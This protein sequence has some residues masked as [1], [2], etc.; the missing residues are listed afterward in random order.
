MTSRMAGPP[1]GRPAG[2]AGRRR[3]GVLVLDSLGVGAAPDAADY[4]EVDPDA[5]TLAHV[6]EA[7]GGL[8]LPVLGE[9]G[10][11]LLTAAPGVPG[12]G[13]PAGL[14]ARLTPTGAGKDSTT[15]HWELMGVATDRPFPTYPDGFPPEVIEAFTRSIGRPVLGNLAASGTEIIERL[16]EEHL[17]TGHPIV[18]T[19]ADSVL[20]IATHLDVVP[21]GR[22][23]TWCRTA[24]GLLTGPHRVG[25]VIARP[26]EGPPGGFR[27]TADRRDFG[28]P[29][30]SPTVCDRL[31]D[32]GVSVKAAGK[33][34]DLFHHRGITRSTPTGD[35]AESMEA[36]TTG[37]SEE[38]PALVFVNAGDL[39]TRFGHRNDPE[40]Y[41]RALERLDTGLATL[42][43]H[44]GPGDRLLITADHGT[45]PTLTASTD[46]TRERVPCLLWGP[47]LPGGRDLGVRST[48]SDVGATVLDL[49]GLTGLP[50]SAGRPLTLSGP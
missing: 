27:R 47:D 29:P 3:V 2:A 12:V 30:P 1:R 20:Q 28:L 46:H 26:F 22:L 24:R 23:Y 42:L 36:L 33:V 32:A 9:L 7:V 43:G 49:F 5:D 14:V 48:F 34:G 39:D 50:R 13:L 21:L 10:L 25:R 35:D 6:A 8:D 17:A 44:L 11:G 45:D 15:G 16:G 38:G 4:G 41:A 18:Y 40:G 37:F 31:Q 19:S